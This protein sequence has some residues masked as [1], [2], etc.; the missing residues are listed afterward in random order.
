MVTTTT[1]ALNKRKT[2]KEIFGAESQNENM[3][4]RIKINY[5]L[6]AIFVTV[7]VAVIFTLRGETALTKNS[8]SATAP[9][10][11]AAKS[12][13]LQT[14]T[15]GNGVVNPGDTLRYTITVQ[16]TGA[17]PATNLV[18]NDTL[19]ANTTLQ[20][21]PIYSPI[22]VNETYSSIG[23]VGINVPDGAGDLLANDL[24]PNGSGTL[25]ITAVNTAGTQGTVNVNMTTGA[26]T[27]N[28]NPGFEGATGFS[29]T[30][31]N[32]T[33]L[34]DTA[35]VT[36]NVSGMIWF[37]DNS[38]GANGDGRLGTPFNSLANF[39]A[40]AAD[41]AG[42]NIFL[43][44]QTAT[45]YTGGITLLA[46]QKLIGQGA[47]A[48][49]A[50]I[51]G[52]TVPTFSNA[53]PA[54]NGTRPTL[55]HSANNVTLSTGNT[56]RGL[57][58][59]ST[60]GSALFATNFNNLTAS[61][62]TAS[63][64]G[65][66]AA[67]NLDNASGTAAINVTFISVS[68]SGSTNGIILADTTGSFTVSGNAGTCTSEATCTGGTIKNSLND[69]IKLNNATNTSFNFMLIDNNDGNG[70][71]GDDITNFSIINSRVTNNGDTVNGTEAGLR[72]NELLGTNAIT[73]TTITG[74]SEDNVRLTP[75]NGILS[76]LA[77]SS[78]NIS[79]CAAPVACNGV[80][81][82]A[83]G[84]A[85]V[86]V[87][88]S[89]S[90]FANNK[91]SAFLT[92]GDN[93]AIQTV[94]IS[95]SRFTGNN[96]GVDLA[97]GG[98]G[99]FTINVSNNTGGTVA[100]G[101]GFFNHASDAIRF[102][103]GDTATSAMNVNAV[104]NNNKIGDRTIDSGS[105]DA[106]GID[107]DFRGDADVI[108]SV[109]NNIISNTDIEGIHAQGRL[110]NVAAGNP[111]FDLNLQNNVINTPDDNSAFPF[112]FLYGV[113]IESRNNWT[114]CMDISGN[115]SASVGGA[116][117][118]RTRQRD[119]S[120]FI[121]ERF[122]DGDG[123]PNEIINNVALV[124][125]FV[126]GQ[127]IGGSTAD[128]TL[129]AGFTE[130]ASGVCRT[131]NVSLSLSSL[132]ATQKADLALLISGET[133][134]RQSEFEESAVNSSNPANWTFVSTSFSNA[135]NL[136]IKVTD[137][138]DSLITPTVHAESNNQPLS[139]ENI[140]KNLGTLPPN[141]S[142]TIRFDALI[143]ANIPTNDFQVSNTANFTADGGINI[144]STTANTTVV[145]PP[146]VS[147]AFGAANIATG[148]NTTLTFTVG[149]ANPATAFTNVAFTDNLPA[150]LVVA[151]PNGLVNNCGGTVSAAAG[152]GTISV[153]ALSRA[154]NS[155]CTIVVN[156]TGTTEGAKNNTTT[157]ISSTQGGTGLTS[158]TA[159]VNIIAA[160]SF[161]KAFGA[162]TIPL[163]G[164][165]SLSFTIT[166]NSAAFSLNNVSFTDNLP[167]GLVVATPPNVSGSC[168]GAVTANAGASS[169]SLS[170]ATLA[171]NGN[172]LFSVNVTGTT[173]G[174]KNNSVQ[175]STTELGAGATANASVTVIAP[176]TIA[177]AFA[178]TSITA[179]G[180]STVTL[181]L[182]NG[183]TTGALTGAAFTDTLTNMS[184]VGGTVGGTCAGTNPT[185][186]PAGATALSFSGI[187]IPNN[188]NCTVTFAVTST[189]AGDH[190]NT[191]SGVTT[192]QT[193]TAGT[194]SNTAM[195]TV[196]AP[197]TIAKSFAPATVAVNGVSTLTI[198][199]TNPA[200][201]TLSLTGVGVT[202]NFPAGLEVDAVAP[203]P[204]NS[205]A[206]GTFAPTAGATSI[207][208]GGATIPTGTA[209][210]F[211]VKV[212]GVTA[213]AKVNT[214]GNVTSTNGG[215]GGTATATLSVNNSFEADVSARPNGNGQILPDDVVQIRRFFNGTDAADQTTD[216]FQRADSAPI[217]TKGDGK[218]LPDDVVQTRRYQNGT[219]AMQ[220]VG[221]PMTQSLS[222]TI[223]EEIVSQA[224]ATAEG[225]MRE[226]RVESTTAVAGQMVT[227]NIRVDAVG[228]EA[229]YGF[230]LSYDPMKLSMPIIG[231]GNA[232]AS[233]RSCN[234]A[235]AGQINCSV[236]GFP[237]NNPMSSDAGIGE[238]A[239]GTNQ[240]L[241]TVT[242]TVG[243][244]TGETPLTLSNVNASSDAPQLFVPTATN[245]TITI[246][247]L[248]AASVPVS[249]RVLSATGRGIPKARLTLT[250]RNGNARYA[251]TNPFGYYRFVDVQAGE[252]YILSVS[253]KNRTF[254]QPTI[255]LNV[256]DQL[257]EVN[258]VSEP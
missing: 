249:G 144:N 98:S 80:T 182:S 236:G 19:D 172:C 203:S 40:G 30:L 168:G 141:E 8:E 62:N 150:G 231:A 246:L 244:M 211:T 183:N 232:G 170:G 109:T 196:I 88:V 241:I 178:P 205:C 254:A 100:S 46:N 148:A 251:M 66:V 130:G 224:I 6:A 94:N 82:I 39:N 247:P 186:L 131:P 24:N 245:G 137:R 70:V 227:V 171:A 26:F 14:D 55:T 190:P 239:A 15:N 31:S 68:A 215:S 136:L 129:V 60:G 208:I 167:V 75:T 92:T 35:T 65:G 149:N 193:P 113:L 57:N 184:A 52:I 97:H 151:T 158:N 257:S 162:A 138:L 119:T 87:T 230:V 161:T 155:T 206:T 133:S 22:A 125:T 209:C 104:I 73:N 2:G 90:T 5:L 160:P 213:G 106:Q 233:I 76:D 135:Y 147:K 83:T 176:P 179:G 210:T 153:S 195:L 4:N 221:G 202:D 229:E 188:G 177:K 59:N 50:S 36:I 156:V 253:S 32:G 218:I 123:T 95:S 49:L 64:T 20:G 42:D 139:G 105:R 10:L 189:T 127:N 37:I 89:S 180:S 204:T 86:K 21:T 223:V 56:V 187:T 11:T 77:I 115:D 199:I 103:T 143:D 258:F 217:A 174:L 9:S 13:V 132:T 61:E 34:T 191:T 214:T 72:F 165:T 226:V 23:N 198:T 173:A 107:I 41:E 197:P 51:T 116:E 63:A 248:T 212:K 1:D 238:I 256:G 99:D 110:D 255:V 58:I 235:T 163:N 194:A 154:A 120:A 84:S 185:T 225:S 67:I 121:L 207:S 43:Y 29:Y 33:G 243:T 44:R 222:R 69:G 250:D 219:D 114:M 201:N 126:A 146:T 48:S 45:N 220:T 17:D 118:F 152:S 175:L 7:V 71:F 78:S 47:T 216:E 93:N 3:K 27:F 200:A 102:G 12:A 140:T 159:T 157:T 124:E 164:T 192:T 91:S 112:G 16:N 240:I 54:T 28:P 38:Q 166:N 242:F 101:N 18:I 169:I 145:H 53:L 85:S 228:D 234:T 252:T 181:T 237:N 79:S 122:S 117:H 111:R 108:V 81:I 74:S 134:V 128:A 142:I 25:T 96:V